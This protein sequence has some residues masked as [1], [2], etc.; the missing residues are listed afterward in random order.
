MKYNNTAYLI[1][2]ANVRLPTEKA[3]GYQ[4]CK[5][6]EA[7]AL[8][9]AKVKLF[10]PYRKQ[11][12]Q[13]LIGQT[14]FDYYGIKPVFEVE[15][16]PNWDVVPLNLVIPDKWFVPIF[17]AHALFWGR[18]ATLKVRREQADLYYTRDSE[19]AYW[20]VRFGLPTVYEGHVV[21]KRGQRWL[22]RQI[23]YH[24]A[25]RMVVVLTS[26]IKQGLINMGIPEEKIVVLPDGVDLAL[27]ESLPSRE[28]CRR[29]LR[30]PLDHFIIGYIGRF[31]TLEME[32]GIPELIEAMAYIPVIDGT[33][34]LLLCV[35][36]PMDAVPAYLDLARRIGLP[37]HRLKFVDRVPNTEVP[38][39]IRACDIAVAPFPNTKHYAYFMSPLKLFE[40][41]AAGVPIVATDLPSIREVLR[42]G[43]NAWL[44]PPSDPKALAEGIRS[45]LENPD[46]AKA[47]AA[48]AKQDAQRYTW[49]Q[50]TATILERVLKLRE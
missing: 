48:R 19:I 13:K 4:I 43:E 9:G 49:T 22:L 17:F 7:F 41:M 23:A 40:Y 18:Y 5:M 37:E 26:F 44:V 38:Y 1:Y 25:L 45:L 35:G 31:R 29:K 39:W 34:P 50:R 20:L 3:H 46:F 32:K 33:R 42:H 27:F 36:G 6:C 14:V 10:H 2:L 24:P 30:L 12:D 8:N 11:M 21:P 28:E 15:T 16:L 47:L